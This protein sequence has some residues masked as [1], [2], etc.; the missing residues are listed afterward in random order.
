MKKTILLF[1][2]LCYGLA[3][4]FSQTGSIT[5]NTKQNPSNLIENQFD[6]IIKPQ[7]FYEYSMTVPPVG[8]QL[9]Y[10][11]WAISQAPFGNNIGYNSFFDYLTYWPENSFLYLRKQ[12]DLSN[13]AL[14]TLKWYLGVDNGYKLFVNGNLVS[15]A[16]ADGYT[17][18]WEYSGTI[19]PVYLNNGINIIAIECEDRGGLTAFDMMITGLSLLNHSISNIQTIPRSDG[20]GIVDVFFNLN[21]TENSYNITLEVSFDGGS[22]YLPISST[23]LSGDVNSIN[24]GSNKHIIWNGVGSF[25]NTFSVQSKVKIIA[26]PN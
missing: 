17:F 15:E 16:Y 5:N 25:P 12:I 1:A 7:D 3:G 2:I 13:F 23:F 24:P 21:G 9:S 11:G 18:R 14:E 10:G 22:T 6:T 26:I 4:A 8:W 19:N 20:S